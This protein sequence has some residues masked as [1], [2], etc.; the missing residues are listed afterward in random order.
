M[1]SGGSN[2]RGAKR[3]TL[4][5]VAAHAGVSRATASLVIRNSPLV[6]DDTRER[7]Q[8]AL[9]KLGYVYNQGAA[10]LRTQRSR[11]VGLVITDITNPFFAELTLGIDQHLNA[12]DYVALLGNTGDSPTKQE[13]LLATM[14]QHGVDGLLLCPAQDTQATTIQRLWTWRVPFVL[15]VRYLVGIE[16]DYVGTDNAL[17]AKLAVEHLLAHGHQRIAFVGGPANSSARRDRLAGYRSALAAW[18]RPFDA[19]LLIACSPTRSEGYRAIQEL[20]TLSDPPTA[21]LCYSDVVAFGAM[22][23]LRSMGRTIG[24]DFAVIGFDDIDEAALWS[25]ALTTVSSVPAEVGAEAA[26]LLIERTANP[27]NAPRQIILQPRLV[28]RASCGC[29]EL[30]RGS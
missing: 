6:A 13:S 25:P 14:H 29:H 8:A 23:G 22:L 7:V 17:G 20:L 11:T 10:S 2:R 16:A 12:A 4:S 18:D 24:A 30:P 21:A 19:S 9:H 28:I 15:V 3:I 27:N 5:D 26:R 1:E